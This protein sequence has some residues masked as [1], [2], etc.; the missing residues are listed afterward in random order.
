[1]KSITYYLRRIIFLSFALFQFFSVSAQKMNKGV[2]FIFNIEEIKN[3]NSIVWYG[4]DLSHSRML[5]FKKFEDGDIILKVHM[6][7]ILAEL[8]YVNSKKRMYEYTRKENIIYD[9]TSIQDLY[10]SELTSQD[11]IAN[12]GNEISI[13]DIKL[14]CKNYVL[15]QEN[16]IGLVIIIES[17]HKPE[18][19]VTGY[20]TFFDIQSREILYATKMKGAA[21]SKSGFNLYWGNGI[22][23]IT[24]YFFDKYYKNL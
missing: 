22:K 7:G 11:F 13:E 21:G 19:Y 8:E 5:D 15:P 20:V 3:S 10:K 17:F 4:Y 16:G 2:E 1:M 6:P 23:R 14:I 12:R 9:M 24:G 18:K